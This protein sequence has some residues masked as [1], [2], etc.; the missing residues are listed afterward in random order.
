[1]SFVKKRK[2]RLYAKAYMRARYED[3]MYWAREQL[4]GKCRI[5]GATDGLEFHKTAASTRTKSLTSIAHGSGGLF[6]SEVLRSQLLCGKCGRRA[7]V[8]GNRERRQTGS[9]G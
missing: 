2:R 8:E 7:V 6:E 9:D 3:R 1:M 4:G 5:C